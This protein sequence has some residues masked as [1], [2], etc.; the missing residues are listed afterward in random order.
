MVQWP[1][2]SNLVAGQNNAGSNIA[3]PL[4]RS[5]MAGQ[6]KMQKQILKRARSLGMSGQLP[7]FQGN[8]PI[9][10][11]SILKDAN[12][13]DNKKGTA[14]MDAL[15]KRYGEIADMWM[16]E[17]VADFGTD[18]WWQL[19]G[20]FNGG[21]APWLE[22]DLPDWRAR[23]VEVYTGLN[24]TDPSAIW[25]YQGWAF[26]EWTTEEQAASLRSF[27]D[28]TPAGKFNIIDMSVNGE[29]EWKMFNYSAFWGSRFVWTTL[30]DFGA[31]MA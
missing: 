20:Y 8:L 13:T 27:I 18:H 16:A 17:M 25:S 30:H 14:W 9:Q 21:T 10:L 24:R 11:K 6:W 1:C 23:G 2:L 12:M 7:G 28:A 15:D 22:S 31:R 3:G 19:D 26:V 5:W 4:P 29:G